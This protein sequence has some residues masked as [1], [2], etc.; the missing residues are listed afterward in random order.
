MANN[1]SNYIYFKRCFFDNLIDG[2][3]NI[4]E[5]YTL[6]EATCSMFS[7][8]IKD[9]NKIKRNNVKNNETQEL[10]NIFDENNIN[11]MRLARLHMISEPENKA[12]MITMMMAQYIYAYCRVTN[13][14]ELAKLIK[15]STLEKVFKLT[16]TQ[17]GQLITKYGEDYYL[18]IKSK[19]ERVGRP[20]K[21]Y[22]ASFN[23][24]EFYTEFKELD[25]QIKDEEFV[26]EFAGDLDWI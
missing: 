23:T 15:F 14:E 1:V 26:D 2:G 17:I 20:K 5:Y 3:Y 12:Q 11:Y 18:S 9:R 8:K 7:S 16:E 4:D 19:Q 13:K 22:Y 25:L 6:C 21:V 24:K 10:P